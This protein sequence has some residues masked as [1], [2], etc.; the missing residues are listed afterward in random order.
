[1][2]SGVGLPVCNVGKS[3]LQIL[4][5]QVGASRMKTVSVLMLLLGASPRGEVIELTG[6]HCMPCQGMSPIVHRLQK[7][8]LPIRQVDVEE[9]Q[10][11]ARRYG[12]SGIPTFLVVVDGKVL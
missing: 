3:A 1:M 9:Q 11:E 10:E 4:H 5:S 8:G 2:P 12:A 6:K 7:E